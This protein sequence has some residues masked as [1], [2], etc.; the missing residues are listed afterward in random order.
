MNNS[1]LFH[2][3]NMYSQV[4]MSTIGPTKCIQVSRNSRLMLYFHILDMLYFHILDM[5]Y[6]QILEMLYFHVLD[7]L[8]FHILDM[9]YFHIHRQQVGHLSKCLCCKK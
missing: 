7:M 9:L 6:F 2:E 4:N 3:H 8:Y 1:G 5:L